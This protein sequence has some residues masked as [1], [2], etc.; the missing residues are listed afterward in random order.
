MSSAADV[1]L[2]RPLGFGFFL[3]VFYLLSMSCALAATDVEFIL[4]ISG[5]MQQKLN[6]EPQIESARKAMVTALDEI[7]PDQLVALRVYAHRIEQTK[8]EE[9]CKDTELLIPF[10]KL[11]KNEFRSKIAAL[12]P[13]GYT[14]IAYSLQESRN[15]LLDVGMGREADRVIILMTD[16]EETCGGDPIAVLKQL[17]SEGF[18]LT[19]YTVGFNVNDVA[20]KQLQEIASFTGGRYFD[21]KDGVELNK[22][23]RDAAKATVVLDEK[24]K[25][26]YGTAI[27]GGDS[28]ET[29]VPMEFNKE[30]RLDHH[31]KQNDLDYFWIEAKRGEAV[32]LTLSTLDRGIAI[33][34]DGKVEE[35][36]HPYA[37]LQLHD[38]N[39]NKLKAI[40]IIGT[41]SKVETLVF[42]PR[43][44]GK[45]FVL[46]GSTYAAMHKDFV[47]F[48]ATKEVKGDLGTDKDAGDSFETALSVEAKRYAKNTIGDADEIDLFSVNAKKGEH[49]VIGVIPDAN[50]KTYFSVRLLDDFKQKLYDKTSASDAGLKSEE[51]EI[52]EDGTYY[53]ELSYHTDS[54][55][56]YTLVVKKKDSITTESGGSSSDVPQAQ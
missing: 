16:G 45:Y 20:R 46:L 18:K 55:M 4:D 49:Y 30:Y 44:D 17:K 53:I 36:S 14:P 28:Y 27:R 5:S 23:L 51:I 40:D 35:T 22:A 50:Q 12:T 33:S 39:R 8:K 6:G 1:F 54:T 56:D 34:P 41:P 15:D 21:A 38:G 3:A 9:S 10:K 11:D 24:K 29:A 13:K 47:T 7:Q 32:T 43:D 31:Q 19:V 37:T 52:P 25:S 48:K 42:Q 26:V 2:R